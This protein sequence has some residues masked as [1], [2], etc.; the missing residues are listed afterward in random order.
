M[1]KKKG[2]KPP[3]GRDCPTADIAT[4][5]EA[6]IWL[7][8]FSRSPGTDRLY[9]AIAAL[10]AEIHVNVFAGLQS[11]IKDVEED[12]REWE[13]TPCPRGV[14]NVRRWYEKRR[15]TPGVLVASRLRSMADVAVPAASPFR[16]WY[17][18]GAALGDYWECSSQDDG[19]RNQIARRVLFCLHALPAPF[20][21]VSGLEPLPRRNSKDLNIEALLQRAVEHAGG[22]EAAPLTVNPDNSVMVRFLDATIRAIRAIPASSQSSSDDHAGERPNESPGTPRVSTAPTNHSDPSSI[23]ISFYTPPAVQWRSSYLGLSFDDH[24]HKVRRADV[25]VDLSSSQLQWN[26]LQVFAS[27]GESRVTRNSLREVWARFGREDNPTRETMY[28]G[29]SEFRRKIR[30]LGLC[31]EAA[32]GLGWRLAAIPPASASSRSPTRQRRGQ[33]NRR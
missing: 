15:W 24:N 16:T 27:H 20:L 10:H 4:K 28:D 32:R 9:E 25:E 5:M 18:L 1:A 7:G 8:F 3:R 23:A 13:Q 31:T 17:D 33:R 6:A 11:A 14:L 21:D 26:I 2:G 22:G 29:L 30:P 12:C 19:Q